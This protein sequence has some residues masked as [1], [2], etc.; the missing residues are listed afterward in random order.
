MRVSARRSIQ[1]VAPPESFE[2]S[3]VGVGRD[4][5][6]SVLE[7]ESGERGVR[8]EIPAEIVRGDELAEDAR[9]LR[10][11]LWNPGDRRLEPRGHLAPGG[12]T[13]EWSS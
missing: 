1:R 2:P 13:V 12:L 5:R 6:H 11:G 9:V 8:D 10:T 7:S 4:D 3:E